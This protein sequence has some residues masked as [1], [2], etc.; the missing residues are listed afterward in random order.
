MIRPVT[1]NDAARIAE[2]YNYYV[3]DTVVTFEEETVSTDEYARRIESLT[4]R[5]FPW[6]VWESDLEIIS[7]WLIL[8]TDLEIIF[9]WLSWGT[10]LEIIS[11]C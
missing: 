11:L 3:T 1:I 9:A 6:L 10:G 5:G 8:E 4:V 2:I 7:A